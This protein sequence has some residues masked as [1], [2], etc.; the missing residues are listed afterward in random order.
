MS[1]PSGENPAS[2]GWRESRK[3]LKEGIA[4]AQRRQA[5]KMASEE[6]EFRKAQEKQQEEEA[7]RASGQP[8]AQA[9]DRSAGQGSPEQAA[10]CLEVVDDQQQT[11]KTIFPSSSR[12]YE[13]QKWFLSHKD[14]D[15]HFPLRNGNEIKP[16]LSGKAVFEEI[17]ASIKKA[18]RS[19]DIITWGLDTD[20]RLVRAGGEYY[21]TETYRG[22][23]P[24]FQ[25][26]DP[27]C[28]YWDSLQGG[29]PPARGAHPDENSWVFADMITQAALRGVKVTILVWEPSYPARNYIDPLH[30]WWKSKTRIIPNIEFAFRAFDG[31][32]SP[33]PARPRLLVTKN[34]KRIHY[35]NGAND[36]IEQLYDN[37]LNSPYLYNFLYTHHQKEVLIDIRAPKH[38]HGY[39]IGCNFKEEYWDT[40]DH[41][42]GDPLRRPYQ[43]WRDMGVK[44]RGPVLGDMAENFR[45]SWRQMHCLSPSE[46]WRHPSGEIGMPGFPQPAASFSSEKER[47]GR[48]L[49]GLTNEVFPAG[50]I[51]S[52]LNAGLTR[53]IDIVNPD[54]LKRFDTRLF[55]GLEAADMELGA[56][57]QWNFRAAPECVEFCAFLSTLADLLS[58]VTRGDLNPAGLLRQ[59][60]QWP[61]APAFHEYYLKGSDAENLVPAQFSRTFFLNN[62][63]RDLSIR[64][65]YRRALR[66]ASHQ[67]FIYF[68]NQYFR[69]L[70]LADDIA[71]LYEKSIEPYVL[72]VTNR[73]SGED[74]K[75]MKDENALAE[76]PT[77]MTMEYLKDAGVNAL[78]C[79]MHVT[80]AENPVPV[81]QEGRKPPLMVSLLDH[82][83][84]A[85]RLGADL[86]PQLEKLIAVRNYVWRELAPYTLTHDLRAPGAR[87]PGPQE[88][89][90]LGRADVSTWPA[91]TAKVQEFR[92]IKAD[93]A[94]FAKTF[95]P[96][97][98]REFRDRLD[99]M[100]HE[101]D[102][103]AFDQNL[104]SML[105]ELDKSIAAAHA[106]IEATAEKLR[107]R[108]IDER[109]GL[110]KER[111]RRA[112]LPGFLDE[113][114]G[115]KKVFPAPDPET[116]KIYALA[117]YYR[118]GKLPRAKPAGTKRPGDIY[119]HSKTMI[120]DE[121]FA[122]TGSANINERSMWHDSETAIS[123]RDAENTLVVSD[124]LKALLNI[125]LNGKMPKDWSGKG[126]YSYITDHL[127]NNAKIYNEGKPL[128]NLDIRLLP[129]KPVS[130]LIGF[131]AGT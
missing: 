117:A 7:L 70:Y 118:P 106:Q 40:A 32:K 5:E 38:A 55:A 116:A 130:R 16:L 111:A 73:L 53:G 104:D 17:A 97:E 51:G 60:E 58:A 84:M 74:G 31:I 13:S 83:N 101:S 128:G 71:A 44:V 2:A 62:A 82:L 14:G 121:A 63:P 10:G 85:H 99:K 35:R 100:A 68:E 96:S 6:D 91:L 109:W 47:L 87:P 86:G 33:K 102:W 41:K 61:E 1:S 75:Y 4:A 11:R 103:D 15:P 79:W 65:A 90:L 56:P 3:T 127:K 119:V 98:F 28:D 18:G 120:V 81:Y 50:L 114:P 105:P 39:I 12:P 54:V 34:G 36:K 37:L 25:H 29:S 22:F 21:R 45:E 46:M 78:F 95:I 80:E 115:E 23:Y 93:F 129:L 59:A 64:A 112:V 94:E 88:H 122:I 48:Q 42:A 131:F 77:F 9:G 110:L 108:I 125:C 67:G 123:F 19:I 52:A 72:V 66:S 126:I 76:E 8:S 89:I 124:M 57:E 24:A 27:P 69:D 49:L 26:P 113:A 20:M 30:L 43:P 92:R 107:S